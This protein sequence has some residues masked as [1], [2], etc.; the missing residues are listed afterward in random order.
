MITNTRSNAFNSNTYFGST[1]FGDDVTYQ[2]QQVALPGISMAHQA[3]A[4][5]VGYIHLQGDI[6]EYDSIRLTVLVDE[7]LVVW[8]ELITIMQKYHVPG[9]N[10]CNPITGDSWIEIR[11]NRNNYLFK[12][13]L[14]NSYIKSI[15]SVTYA[16]NGDNEIIT[17]DVDMVF[18]YFLIVD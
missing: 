3:E 8:K 7:K 10:L 18:D 11:D 2:I 13:E 4:T 1:I 9:T 14:K 16:T 17:V 5:K 15:G 12:L 6:A